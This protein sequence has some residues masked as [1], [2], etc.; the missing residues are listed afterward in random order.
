RVLRLRAHGTGWT[1]LAA[2]APDG[3]PPRWLE[4]EAEMVFV[5][6]GAVQ[7]P[8]LLRRSG[9]ARNV[10]DALGMHPMIKVAALF[11][12]EVNAPDMGVPP[13]QVKEFAPQVSLGCSI[14]SPPFLA[15]AMIDHADRFEVVDRSWRHMAVYYA[16]STGG[17]GTVRPLPAFADPLV[18]YRLTDGEL[19]EL[20]EALVNLGRCLFAA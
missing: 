11:P 17:A 2:H 19:A 7:T 9:I 4:I 12:D 14:S 10:G 20:R 15:L 5:C 8:A 18:R 6:A 1:A 16:M 13:H 3:R